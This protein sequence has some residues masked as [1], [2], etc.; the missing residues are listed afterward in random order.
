MKLYHYTSVKSFKKIWESQSL[1]FSDSK[2]TNDVFEKRKLVQVY[3]VTFPM[4]YRPNSK[5]HPFFKHFF[6]LLSSYRQISLCMDYSDDLKGFASPMMWGQ[7]ANGFKG[8]CIELDSE[9]LNL[10]NKHVWADKIEYTDMVHE[11]TFDNCIFHNDEDIFHFI[12]D[13]MADI[14]F[15]K[16]FH[17]QFE[18]E[19]R[20]IS[21]KEFFLSIKGAITAVYVPDNK[22]Y[23]FRTIDKLIDGSCL[24]FCY[25]FPVI[26]KRGRTLSYMDVETIRRC[27]RQFEEK[28]T[29]TMREIL[30]L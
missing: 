20:I 14:F 1:K 27:K 7:Y 15:K 4:K 25:M 23:A 16:H 12:E 30:K 21:N 19:F 9:K 13:R 29:F 8:V 18:N 5:G 17:W 3:K 26:S 2:K 24:K 28:K 6:G 22:G 11:I 10:D